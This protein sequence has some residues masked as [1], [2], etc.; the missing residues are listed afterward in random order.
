MNNKT[1][2]FIIF[3][4]TMM[5]IAHRRTLPKSKVAEPGQ[6]SLF[7]NYQNVSGMKH[8]F[9]KLFCMTFIP[10]LL[11]DAPYTLFS[12]RNFNQSAVGRALIV[13]LTIAFYHTSVQPLI[14]YLPAF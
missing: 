11:S 4:L 1:I 3:S 7:N 5:Y 8:D 13:A 12:V 2:F 9:F 14:N 10:F 6:T